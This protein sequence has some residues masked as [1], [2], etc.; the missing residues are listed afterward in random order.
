V[1]AGVHH[2]RRRARVV[3]VVHDL[4]TGDEEKLE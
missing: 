3:Q 4:Q 2:L 1:H